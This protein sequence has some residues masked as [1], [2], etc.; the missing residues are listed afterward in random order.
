M[1]WEPKRSQHTGHLDLIT[2][3]G[4]PCAALLASGGC[5]FWEA[6]KDC[7]IEDVSCR[8]SLSCAGFTRPR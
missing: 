8:K 7:A 6:K 4:Y 5:C 1:L 3:G 2:F